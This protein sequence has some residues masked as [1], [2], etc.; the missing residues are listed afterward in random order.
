MFKTGPGGSL[1]ELLETGVIILV[2]I[3]AFFQVLLLYIINYGQA[4]KYL[5][6]FLALAKFEARLLCLAR[7]FAL[8]SFQLKVINDH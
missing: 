8:I 4:K 3:V 6:N 1:E 7:T 2:S 5:L